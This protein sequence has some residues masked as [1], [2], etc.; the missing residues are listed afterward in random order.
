MRTIADVQTAFYVDARVC[1]R[2]D[3]LDER[4]RIDDHARPMTACCFGRKIPHGMSWST[5]F[6]LPMMTVWPALWPPATRAM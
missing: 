1:E 2:F 4:A 5:C 3:F 6:S